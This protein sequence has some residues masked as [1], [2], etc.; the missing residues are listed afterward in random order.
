[1]P[2]DLTNGE[3]SSWR[4]VKRGTAGARADRSLLDAKESQAVTFHEMEKSLKAHRG[5]F[6]TEQVTQPT[7]LLS[8]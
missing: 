1:M 7:T 4:G 6:S 8:L 2:S 3:R 5:T